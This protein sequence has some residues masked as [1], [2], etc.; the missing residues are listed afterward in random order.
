M[1]SV[2]ASVLLAAIVACGGGDDTGKK[3][4]MTPVDAGPD[5]FCGN[6]FFYTGE[7]V[8][9]DS[10]ANAF[11]GIFNATLS[12]EGDTTTRNMTHTPPNGRFLL[13]VT[14][15][16]DPVMDLTPD[17]TDGGSDGS[18]VYLPGV[19]LAKHQVLGTGSLTSMRSM[20]M[21]R[22]ATMFEQIGSAYD[23]AK[24]Q[25]FVHQTNT[26]GELSITGGHAPTQAYGSS[27]SW[28]EGDIGSYVFFPNVETTT[29]QLTSAESAAVGTGSYAVAPGKITYV[30][31]TA[32]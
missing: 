27:E 19:A 2:L 9:W 8:D 30:E 15:G 18:D 7:Y 26:L 13:C 24:G 29:V 4:A 6:D 22:V 20:R 28:A 14:N 16:T 1:R 17:P 21:S 25:L 3:D 10:S 5:A 32:P 11:L 23:P 12:V 31:L